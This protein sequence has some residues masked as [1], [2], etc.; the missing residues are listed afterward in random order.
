[1]AILKQMH[2]FNAK[3]HM[4]MKARQL[5]LCGTLIFS[6]GCFASDQEYTFVLPSK[7]KVTIVEA[8]FEKR[9][10]SFCPG[11]RHIPQI[12]DYRPKTYVKSITALF[13][14]HKIRFDVTCMYD[15]WNGR[16]LEHKGVIRYF[17]GWCQLHGN[18]PYCA[19]RG[20]FSDASERFVA[21][22]HANGLKAKRTVFTSSSD[23]F[24]LFNKNIDPPD[25]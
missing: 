12:G 18:K 21:E 11:Y 17:G 1:M 19:F 4:N 6:A 2:L 7:V 5:L 22:W 3:H 24:E 16:T 8:P 13:R 25:Y 15:A 10:A 9:P 14:G 20:I 23:I